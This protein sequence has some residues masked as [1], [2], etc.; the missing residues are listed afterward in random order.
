MQAGGALSAAFGAQGA[1]ASTKSTLAFRSQIGDIN[2][3]STMDTAAI[4]QKIAEAAAQRTLLSGERDVQKN[5][6]AASNLKS[7]QKVGFAANGIDLTSGSVQNTLNTTDVMSEIDQHTIESNAVS[8][9]WGYRTQGDAEFARANTQ[10]INERVQ[11]TQDRGASAAINPGAALKTSLLGSA[12]QV[13]QSWYQTRQN[14]G[15]PS[16][17]SAPDVPSSSPWSG[18]GLKIKGK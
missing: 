17:A 18:G 11:A 3:Q 15:A 8:Q 16:M 2:A 6:I 14:F 13:A 12:G 1:A 4:N 10:A 7:T 9:A 5:Q